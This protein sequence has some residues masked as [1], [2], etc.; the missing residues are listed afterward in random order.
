MKR[1]V[2]MSRK[3]FI[4]SSTS[5]LNCCLFMLVLLI[6]I[7][8]VLTVSGQEETKKSIQII[9][10]RPNFSLSIKLDKGVGATYTPGEM[11]R[12]S[13][14]ASKD[15][16]VTLFRYDVLG[17]VQLLFPNQNQKNSL[18]EANRNYYV[19]FMIERGTLSGFEYIQG[20]AT[21]EPVLLTREMER[22]LG[23]E[24]LPR[25]SEE[26]YSFIQNIRGILTGL[27]AQKWVS[28]EIIHYQILERRPGT[29]Q[30]WVNSHPEG[31][32]VYLNGR[33]VGQTPLELAQI[34]A[35]EYLVQVELT[36]YESWQREVQINDS[37]T[38][39]LSA[40][41]KSTGQYGTIVI[42]CDVDLAR[43][44]LDGQF[45]RLTHK[46][47]DIVLDDIPAGFHDLSIILSGYH[48]WSQRIEVKP[49]QKVQLTI[50]LD[51]IIRTGS[52]EITGNVDNAL[53][54]LDEDYYGETSSS[55][56]TTI[57]N[58]LEGSYQL[59]IVKEGYDDYVTTVRIYPD[60]ISKIEVT[61]QQEYQ[62]YPKG[63]IAVYCNEDGA[64]IFLN[65]FYL[66]TSSADQAQIMEVSGEGVYEITV[67]KEGYHTW[68]EE[69]RV[70]SGE[71]SSVF[72]DL[73]KI[74]K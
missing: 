57:S 46:N 38:T 72:V 37:R 61:M 30:L 34:N 40:D 55:G 71:I 8:L 52:L 25:L 68:Q 4:I 42:Q 29:G 20:F 32:S 2:K 21:T 64:R 44:Y 31:A 66:T 65:G 41:L 47:R 19:D 13:F 50:Y 60:R 67:I 74:E 49:N 53:I 17:N 12:I 23:E 33:Y 22:R 14:N 36:G 39:F 73:V 5:F 54:Y 11:V 43:I 35:E 24:F 51:K 28:S 56:R 1:S 9:N 70:N 62:E 58:I 27:P 69:V 16:Y 26:V 3:K 18:V 10:P 48:D 59:R 45:K 63:A 6:A 7:S 15:T